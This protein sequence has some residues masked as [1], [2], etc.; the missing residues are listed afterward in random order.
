MGE[1][2]MSEYVWISDM[3]NDSE[4]SLYVTTDALERDQEAFFEGEKRLKKGLSVPQESCPMRIWGNMDKSDD[5]YENLKEVPDLFGCQG[6]YIV[7]ERAANVLKQFD[8]GGGALYPVREG[9]YQDDNA[10]QVAGN[11]FTWIFGNVKSGF[12]EADS[13]RADALV[14]GERDWCSMPIMLRDNDIAVSS[15]VTGNPDVWIDRALFKSVFLS[16]PLGEALS[17]AG[18]AKAFHLKKCRVI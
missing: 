1:G 16:G 11:Y 14:N 12:L 6:Y 4:L 17:C 10:T 9:I 8:L 15:S 7:S 18:L 13:P 3:M 2:S 5:Y